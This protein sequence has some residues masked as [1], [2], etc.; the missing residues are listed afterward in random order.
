MTQLA[1]Y[2]GGKVTVSALVWDRILDALAANRA[3]WD[4]EEHSVKAEHAELIEEL[5]SLDHYLAAH[6]C[7]NSDTLPSAPPIRVLVA[8]EG[9]CVSAVTASVP[10]VQLVTL[11]YDTEGADEADLFDIPQNGGGTA[12]AFRSVGECDHDTSG[13]WEGACNARPTD[14]EGRVKM[15]REMVAGAGDFADPW[16]RELQELEAWLAEGAAA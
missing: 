3:A 8:L 6:G 11:D 10:G 4:G 7:G 15:L 16:R 1:T 5:E 13:F 9:G 12:E 14:P 2:S